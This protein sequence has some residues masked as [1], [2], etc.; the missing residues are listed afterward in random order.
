MTRQLL[1][2]SLICGFALSA[3]GLTEEVPPT[4]R[5]PTITPTKI[6]TPLPYV[7]TELPA[8][9]DDDNPIQI[10]IVPAD[11][12]VASQRLDEFESALQNLTD[13]VISVVLADNDDEAYDAVCASSQGIVSAGW[14]DGMSFVANSL[15]NCGI[16]ILQAQTEAGTGELGVMLVNMTANETEGETDDDTDTASETDDDE[17]E[18]ENPELVASANGVICRLGVDD[19]YSWTLPVLYYGAEGITPGDLLEVNDVTNNDELI[20][21]LESGDCDA[22]GMSLADWET[23]LEADEDGSLADAVE[24]VFTSPEIPYNVFSFS[25]AL[26][27]DAIA[28]ISDAL[29][30]MEFATG[31]VEPSAEATEDPNVDL[32]NSFDSDLLDAFFGDAVLIPVNEERLNELF[33]LFSAT[34][35]NFAELND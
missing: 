11:S 14:L 3:C 16:G 15:A 31:R 32:P 28:D 22:G 27:L 2:L 25:S 17:P 33:S 6:S 9:F 12:V 8:G 30:Q 29:L 23:Y 21:D 18:T 7:P 26:S 24:V 34:G 10:V 5:P 35:I 4:P 20:A 19:L 13:V 1:L